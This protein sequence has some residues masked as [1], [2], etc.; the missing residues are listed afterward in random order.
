MGIKSGLEGV[1]ITGD[2]AIKAEKLLRKYGYVSGRLYKTKKTHLEK[3]ITLL[4]ELNHGAEN[5]IVMNDCKYD[6]WI[7]EQFEKGDLDF[8]NNRGRLINEF[9]PASYSRY[10]KSLGTVILPLVSEQSIL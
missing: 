3:L 5:P 10:W 9:N 4:D 8:L 7:R 1:N 6:K 2:E